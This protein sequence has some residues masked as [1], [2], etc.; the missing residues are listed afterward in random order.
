MFNVH[1]VAGPADLCSGVVG[2]EG[3]EDVLLVVETHVLLDP[4]FWIFVREED[5]V[6]VDEDAWVQAWE[7][8]EEL[9]LHVAVDGEDVA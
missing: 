8:L 1:V 3:L 7:D 4:V 2:E 6:D 9:V 5:V